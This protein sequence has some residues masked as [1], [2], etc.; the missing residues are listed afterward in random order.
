[1]SPIDNRSKVQ[2][3]IL[4]AAQANPKIVGCI[5]YGS[6]S[7]GRGD[8]WSDLDIALFIQDSELE[9]FE[10]NWK[11]WASQ[12]GNLL[13]AYIG[14][15]GHP[16]AVYDATPLPLR[17]DF[18]FFP[19]SSLDKILKWPCSPISV[20]AMV[21]YDDTNGQIRSHVSQIVGQSL[22]PDDLAKAF[23]QVGGDF[24]YYL[25]RTHTKL[26]RGEHWA[27]RHDFN[28]IITGNLLALL[29]IECDA[30]SRWRGSSASSGIEKVLS[31]GRLEQLN[32][33]IPGPGETDL[34]SAL[35]RAASLGREVS[36]NIAQ[37]HSLDWPAS[38]AKKVLET[39]GDE[40]SR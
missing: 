19:V 13:L 11:Q 9:L 8:K 29:Q 1:M 28:F 26:I 5:D 25:L 3:R 16:W 32:E 12:F 35:L 24:W 4:E 21:L 23:E 15:V 2:Q 33:C 18:V 6:T 36:E 31:A 39:L 30:V 27:A 34:K 17:V 7:E 14:G 22:A 38:L 10:K 40:I 37:K 20:E